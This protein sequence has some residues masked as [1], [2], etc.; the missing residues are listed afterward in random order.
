VN[1]IIPNV[2]KFLQV[3]IFVFDRSCDEGMQD[4]E[5]VLFQAKKEE[6]IIQGIFQSAHV[7]EQ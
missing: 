4:L 2:P 3:F 7:L 5:E 1:I 6:R